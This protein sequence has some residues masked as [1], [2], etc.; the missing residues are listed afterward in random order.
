MGPAVIPSG[1]EEVRVLYSWKRRLEAIELA[2]ICVSRLTCTS[3]GGGMK[4]ST[5]SYYMLKTEIARD[6]LPT[7]SALAYQ[8][9]EKQDASR[10]PSTS[11]EI[12]IT[13]H[14]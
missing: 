14:L 2:M 11:T 7:N 3:C 5:M 4:S 13:F 10:V 12:K 1:G 9:N 6:D 8:L